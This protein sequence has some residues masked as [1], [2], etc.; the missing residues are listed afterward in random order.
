MKCLIFDPSI[1]IYRVLDG[2]SP[3]ALYIFTEEWTKS[4]C[5]N[6]VIFALITY[7]FHKLATM[8][9]Q[10]VLKNIP[11]YLSRAVPRP[12]SDRQRVLEENQ[13]RIRH[14]GSIQLGAGHE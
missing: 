6:H 7:L 8:S 3:S 10:V 1:C 9:Y 11:K 12:N 4:L 2:V 5:F 14:E 13:A